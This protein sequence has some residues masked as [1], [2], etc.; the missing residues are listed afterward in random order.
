MAEV[1]GAQE[2]PNH[3]TMTKADLVGEV[4]RVSEL[5]RKEAEA[6]VETIFESIIDALQKDDKIEIRGFGSFR[7]RERRGRTGRNPKTGA[8]VEV[9]AKKIPFFKPSKELKDYVNNPQEAGSAS[10]GAQG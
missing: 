6:V 3:T 9:P 7:T 5:S 2:N 4:E 8:K 1:A 10:A